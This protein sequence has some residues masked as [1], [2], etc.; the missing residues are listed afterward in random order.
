MR[1]TYYV[2]TKLFII[3]SLWFAFH[4]QLD[5]SNLMTSFIIFDFLNLL[6][7]AKQC[8]CIV[9]RNLVPWFSR[10]SLSKV[11]WI[12]I[13]LK[14][15][16]CQEILSPKVMLS[17]LRSRYLWVLHRLAVWE[18]FQDSWENFTNEN[19]LLNLQTVGM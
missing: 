7:H 18:N 9:P 17:Y 19:F 3:F 2:I 10:S 15:L 1:W 4:V 14:V 12:I 6:Y 16:Q 13:D 8:S 11:F 5:F